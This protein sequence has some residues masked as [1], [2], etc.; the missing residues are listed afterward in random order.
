MAAAPCGLLAKS[1]QLKLA[2]VSTIPKFKQIFSS[3]IATVMPLNSCKK[4]T[5]FNHFK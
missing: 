2:M 1:P 4:Q 3:P 5:Q